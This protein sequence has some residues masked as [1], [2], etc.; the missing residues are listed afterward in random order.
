[1]IWLWVILGAVV[2]GLVL[3]FTA[4]TKAHM[5]NLQTKYQTQFFEKAHEIAEWPDISDKRLA[6]LAELSSGLRSR[7]AQ[8]I[9]ISAIDLAIKQEKKEGPLKK[10]GQELAAHADMTQEQQKLWR[11][12]Y[13]RWMLA[14]CSQG[15]IIGAGSLL[16]ILEFFDPDDPSSN[17]VAIPYL[18]LRGVS[19]H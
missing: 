16:K 12:M 7:K 4:I 2:V 19:A 11:G 15:S 1:M 8:M 18:N 17:K 14:V 10:N 6:A 5:S 3:R 13:F 9:L